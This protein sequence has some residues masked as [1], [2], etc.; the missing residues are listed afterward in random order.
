VKD[1]G[2]VDQH[3]KRAKLC[4]N[5]SNG[6]FHLIGLCHITTRQKRLPARSVNLRHNR[7]QR[8]APATRDRDLC[9]FS[10]KLQSAGAA[11]AGSAARD[12]GHFAG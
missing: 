8:L 12:Q 1:S 5:F 6:S 10:R 9:A 11:N 7:G 4:D 3:M 2:V